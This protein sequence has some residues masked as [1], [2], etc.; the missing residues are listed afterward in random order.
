MRIGRAVLALFPLLSVSI[1]AQDYDYQTFADSIAAI[2]S[3]LFSAMS[4]SCEWGS[5]TFAQ[6][7]GILGVDRGPSL[8]RDNTLT[9]LQFTDIDLARRTANLHGTSVG[10]LRTGSGLTFIEQTPIGNWVV[11]T[12][13]A[14]LFNETGK[15]VA[16]TSRHI[17]DIAGAP[18]MPSQYHG[19]CVVNR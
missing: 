9:P 19:R 15:Y 6:Y 14:T 8:D 4:I 3:R 5:G 18:P 12:V 11:T 1:V 7:R 16:V 2:E 10:V 17:A 13:F